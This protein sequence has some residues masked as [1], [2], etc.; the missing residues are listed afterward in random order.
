MTIPG[1]NGEKAVTP[2]RYIPGLLFLP[3]LQVTWGS[4][5]II[6]DLWAVVVTRGVE[7][8][9]ERLARTDSVLRRVRGAHSIQPASVEGA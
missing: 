9:S 2:A 4:V 3:P 6:W 5:S 7:T 8:L 1:T